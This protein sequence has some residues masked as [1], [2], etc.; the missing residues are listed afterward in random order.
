MT[1]EEQLQAL[2]T[3]WKVSLP[4]QRKIIEARAKLL[5]MQIEENKKGDE[6]VETAKKIFEEP[7]GPFK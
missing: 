4:D 3:E 7:F 1:L 2:R 6:I 5:K